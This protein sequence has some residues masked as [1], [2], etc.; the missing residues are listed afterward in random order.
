MPRASSISRSRPSASDTST[1]RY[2]TAN[3]PI[4]FPNGTSGSYRI[5][6]LSLPGMGRVQ[7]ATATND[8]IRRWKPLYVLLVGIAGGIAAAGVRL[9]D[10]LV[11]Y[12]VVDYEL[13]KL[14][15]SGPQVRWDVHRAD[16]R[17][18]T[19]ARNLKIRDWQRMITAVR[20]EKG[21]PKRHIGP[22]ASGD[23]VVAVEALITKYRETWPKLIGVEMEASGA[24]TAAFNAPDKPSFFMVRGVSDLANQKKGSATVEKWRAYACDVAAAYTIALLQSGPIPLRPEATRR[25]NKARVR[26]IQAPASGA[27]GTLNKPEPTTTLLLP[28]RHAFT[29]HDKDVFLSTSLS[30]IKRY[31]QRALVKLKRDRKDISTDLTTISPRKFI[32]TI[33]LRGEV[34]NRCKIWI[35]DSSFEGTISY[36]HGRQITV[37]R[38]TLSHDQLTVEATDDALFLRTYNYFTSS[39]IHLRGGKLTASEA[40]EH[41]WKRF[42]EALS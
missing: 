15:A 24:A 34:L 14:T 5:A 16:P 23:K 22:I 26:R 10:V 8:A 21:G 41:L 40:A 33:Y 39:I 29:Q 2:Y 32:A 19:A 42:S 30:S 11:S 28:R 4:R 27:T 7:A 12:Q 25:N 31:F 17:L 9:G 37:D 20:P 35:S 1:I 13:Q 36:A 18:I 3:L 38:D 6:V